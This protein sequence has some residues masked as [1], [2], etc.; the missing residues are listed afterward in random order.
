VSHRV[1][2][3]SKTGHESTTSSW[4]IVCGRMPQLIIIW[5][6]G[7]ATEL[8]NASRAVHLELPELAREKRKTSTRLKDRSS[9]PSSFIRFGAH[10]EILG[11]GRVGRKSL[12]TPAENTMSILF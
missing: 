10:R 2:D 3:Q 11:S 5:P 7:G 8:R 4:T 1:R 9:L 12:I 6:F